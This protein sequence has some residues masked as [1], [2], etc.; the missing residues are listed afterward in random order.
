MKNTV[1]REFSSFIHRSSDIKGAVLIFKAD[2]ILLVFV[3]SLFGPFFL[4]VL[5]FAFFIFGFIGFVFLI[6]F[7]GGFLFHILCFFFFRSFCYCRRSFFRSFVNSIIIRFGIVR[8]L[9]II[10]IV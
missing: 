9:C 2:S 4:V 10:G 8:I 6:L 1:F 5:I 7:I 3:G